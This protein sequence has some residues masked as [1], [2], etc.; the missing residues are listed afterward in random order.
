[1][2]LTANGAT[3][4]ITSGAK[5]ASHRTATAAGLG[6]R[7]G[8][9]RTSPPRTDHAVPLC[10]AA[11][12]DF[13]RRGRSRRRGG[14]P[15]F[16]KGE[17]NGFLECGILA[18]GFLRLRCGDCGHEERVAFYSKRCGICPGC[19]ARRMAQTAAHLV[20]HVI[21]RCRY[22]SG[23]CR[24]RSHCTGYRPPSR[25]VALDPRAG[26]SVPKLQNA[27]M[28]DPVCAQTLC[29]TALAN[30][31]AQC[32]AA[33]EVVLRSKTPWRDSTTHL[34]MSP[35][36][37]MPRQSVAISRTAA[38]R[39]AIHGIECL[40]RV[41][42]HSARLCAGLEHGLAET[43]RSAG[44]AGNGSRRALLITLAVVQGDAQDES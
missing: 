6:W 26:Q 18:H 23:S 12:W 43:R 4:A 41:V 33:G 16:V 19:A 28:R 24:C 31:R 15:Q 27:M 42:M 37:I 22:A 20:D 11:R 35:L 34:V 14:L 3:A 21:P 2:E 36:D 38:L 29:A 13:L 30:E 7:S 5:R 8:L 17:F 44:A 25:R 9:Q 32:N 1:M 39:R 40:E 10:A